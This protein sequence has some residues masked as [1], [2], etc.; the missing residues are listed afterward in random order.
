MNRRALAL[1]LLCLCSAWWYGWEFSRS[2]KVGLRSGIVDDLYPLWNGAHEL[3][4]G[5]DPYSREVTEENEIGMY[6]AT[7]ISL[8]LTK[9]Q[10]FVYPLPAILPVIPLQIFNFETANAIVFVAFLF[11]IP[12]CVG[13][14]R[15]KWD[16]RTALY[17]I[18]ALSTYPIV[19]VVQTRQPT[20][21]YIG[22][23]LFATS[24]LRRGSPIAAGIVASLAAC[25]P[26]VALPILL[27]MAV[28]SI[29]R[30]WKF[31]VSLAASGALLTLGF[32]LDDPTWISKWIESMRSYAQTTSQPSLIMQALGKPV[33]IPL[34]IAACILLVGFLWMKRRG[35]LFLLIS[36][37]VG[38][39]QLVIP[40]EFYNSILLLIPIVWVFDHATGIA[41]SFVRVSLAE[42]WACSLAG[43]ILLHFGVMGDLAWRLPTVMLFPIVF[44]TVFAVIQTAIK[45]GPHNALRP[46]P[47]SH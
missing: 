15:G 18:L 9:G 20:L 46:V 28:W 5:R 36:A 22:L 10:R 23:A 40:W 19:F 41:V 3:L 4:R 33:G 42:Y 2:V 6:G 47:E 35:D 11:S 8:G 21:L 32:L 30:A 26:H 7:A 45:Y 1:A 25:K 14:I 24:L 27:P 29:G 13:W 17:S 38:I 43:A 44:C 31:T 37:A 12:M 39:L 16:Q 34:S